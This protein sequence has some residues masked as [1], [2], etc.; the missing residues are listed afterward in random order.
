[1][2]TIKME[3]LPFR[4]ST[5]EWCDSGDEREPSCSGEQQ[6][7]SVGGGLFVRLLFRPERE[8]H[9]AVHRDLA[10]NA[11]RAG[12]ESHTPAQA[13]H[14]R[15][16]LDHVA[17]MYRTTI[18]DALDAHEVDQTLPIFWLRKNHDRAD[19]RDRFGENRRRQH[20]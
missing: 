3:R 11:R 10:V 18:P 16:D 12:E 13:Q 2:T 20:R 5:D 19:L 1:M 4:G 15:L 8:R 14:S 17:W 7:I 9:R 6:R